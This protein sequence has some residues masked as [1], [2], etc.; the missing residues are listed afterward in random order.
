MKNTITVTT[1][2][3]ANER[4]SRGNVER[5]RAPWETLNMARRPFRP[6]P[7]RVNTKNHQRGVR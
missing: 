7:G 6:A 2:F 3:N 1:L 4:L 5:G